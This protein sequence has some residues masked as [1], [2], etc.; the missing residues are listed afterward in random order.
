LNKDIS[1][2][3]SSFLGRVLIVVCLF[4]GVGLFSTTVQA[5][6]KGGEDAFESEEAAP[7]QPSPTVAPPIP[8]SSPGGTAAVVRSATVAPNIARTG[9]PAEAGLPGWMSAPPELHVS[10]GLDWHGNIELDNGYVQYTADASSFQKL[11]VYDSRGRFVL[12]PMFTRDLGNDYFLRVTGQV[13][14]WVREIGGSNYQINADDV[15]VQVGQQGRW[16]FM[17][18]RFLTWRVFRKGL[19][20]DLYTLEDT[21]ARTTDDYTDSSWFPHAYEVN[22]IFLRD[23]AIGPSGKA[24]FHLYPTSWSGIELVGT[25]GHLNNGQDVLGGRLAAGLKLEYFSLLAG[26]EYQAVSSDHQLQ[27]SDSTPCDKCNTEKTYGVGGSLAFTPV[28]PVEI[29]VSF[30]ESWDHNYDF[31]NALD[32]PKTTRSWG[33]YGQL[34]AGSLF[35][36]RSLFVGGAFFR[37]ECRGILCTTT[38]N[39]AEEYDRH[40]QLAAYFAYPLGFNNAVVKLVFSEAIGYQQPANPPNL[41]AHMYSVRLRFAYYY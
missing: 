24:A 33:G 2:H 11:T 22:T 18:G 14:A 4:C 21:G 30:A 15:Y 38:A 28:R 17:A 25:Y 34:D 20:F 6:G 35:I 41:N 31:Q 23:P 3:G 12:G 13:V 19:G 29:T 7:A 32:T 36:P 39:N 40:D 8:S 16:D 27:L 26:A 5:Q 9:V 10:P 37:T 1:M